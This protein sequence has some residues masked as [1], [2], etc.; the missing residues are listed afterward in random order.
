MKTKIKTYVDHY[1][2]FDKR[3]DLDALKSEIISNLFERYD[4]AIESGLEA[5]EAYIKTVKSMGDFQ[6]ESYNRMDEMDK[7][8]PSLPEY[9][10]PASAILAA[11][12]L[13]LIFLNTVVGGVLTATSII[14]YAVGGKYLYAKAMY[15]KSHDLDIEL[16]E[17]YLTKI[18]K[19]MKTSFA[20]WSISIAYLVAHIPTMISQLVLYMLNSNVNTDCLK[21]RRPFRYFSHYPF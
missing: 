19:Y 10:L 3:A 2:R 8:L 17:N 15:A 18:F 11:F 20:F 13:I 21:L 6:A 7:T 14:L 5:E 16:H 12:A 1:F 9:L 4:A